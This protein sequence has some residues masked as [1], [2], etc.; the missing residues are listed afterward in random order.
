VMAHFS[1][2]QCEIDDQSDF[3]FCESASSGSEEVIYKQNN[4][5]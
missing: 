2:D 4:L 3:D 1:I 5:L